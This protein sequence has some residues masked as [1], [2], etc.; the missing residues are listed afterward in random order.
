MK[1]RLFGT[2]LIFLASLSGCQPA[3]P[4]A[5]VPAGDSSRTSLDW[6]GTYA[7]T[8]PCADCEG[9]RTTLTLTQAGSYTLTETYQGKDG[10][11][12]VTRGKFVWDDAGAMIRLGPEAHDAKFKVGEGRLWHL[13]RDGKVIV[14]ALADYY[15]LTRQP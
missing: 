7:G 9:I 2:A 6:A 4:P 1:A 14:G 15:V 3:S 10:K 13:D 12:F 11:P 5:T 8:L